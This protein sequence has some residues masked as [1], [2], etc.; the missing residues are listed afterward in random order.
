VQ[1][2]HVEDYDL[3][4]KLGT[5]GKF[6]NLPTYS[7]TLMDRGGSLTSQNRTSQAMHMLE[8]V[9]AFKKKYPR[10]LMGY[11]TS[12][13]RAAFFSVY[14]YIPFKKEIIYPLKKVYKKYW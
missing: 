13:S 8:E 10:F 9:I 3:W 2:K 12:L 6:A 11:L 7:V 5:M 4:L 14:K 1:K